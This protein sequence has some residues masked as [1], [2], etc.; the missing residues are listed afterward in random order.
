MNK[1]FDQDITD[2]KLVNVKPSS[3]IPYLWKLQTPADDNVLV[4]LCAFGDSNTPRKPITGD[5]T[6]VVYLMS[7]S[8]TGSAV[9][10]KDGLG[11]KP[12]DSIKLIF[13]TTL[14]IIRRYKADLLLF[15]FPEGKMKGQEGVLKQVLIMLAKNRSRGL[16]EVIES[17]QDVFLKVKTKETMQADQIKEYLQNKTYV[18]VIQQTRLTTKEM[19]LANQN[20]QKPVG[21]FKD[22]ETFTFKQAIDINLS[23]SLDEVYEYSKT[24]CESILERFEQ[25]GINLSD[26]YKQA[27]TETLSSNLNN[28]KTITKVFNLLKPLD[29]GKSELETMISIIE[30]EINKDN[31]NLLESNLPDINQ[32][33]YLSVKQYKKSILNYNL[34]HYNSEC[35]DLDYPLTPEE[36]Q[37]ISNL[38]SVIEEHAVRLSGTLYKNISVYELSNLEQG[39]FYSKGFMSCSLRPVWSEEDSIL[40]VINTDQDYALILG[41]QNSE[42]VLPRGTVLKTRVK[43][44]N[45]LVVCFCSVESEYNINESLEDIYK[46]DSSFVEFSRFIKPDISLYEVLPIIEQEFRFKP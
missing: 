44:F 30:D 3:R 8:P 11:S 35:P 10:L 42:I 33:E 36:E 32:Q 27:V 28:I 31:I 12:I 29:T 17:D 9:Q 34:E 13:D 24:V 5:K 15:K 39:V 41:G 6:L 26:E 22:D 38:D 1:L 18:S 37:M 20:Y 4:R 46:Q 25:Q 19:I 2:L 7:L 45:D 40:L 23:E 21:N 14:A 16:L 43:K